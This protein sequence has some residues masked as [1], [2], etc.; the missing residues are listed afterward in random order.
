[1]V[2]NSLAYSICAAYSVSFFV[3]CSSVQCVPVYQQL[4]AVLWLYP[5]NLDGHDLEGRCLVD[6]HVSIEA[7]SSC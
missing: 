6:H 1:M 4:L 3:V 7:H 5:N 2:N